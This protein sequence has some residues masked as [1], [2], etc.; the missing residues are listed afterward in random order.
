MGR[1]SITLGYELT[2]GWEDD[3]ETRR[4]IRRM[5]QAMADAEGE[6]VEV[7]SDD[8]IVLDAIDPRGW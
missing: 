4:E 5:A 1:A 6:A 2:D 8:G 7:Y 3:E